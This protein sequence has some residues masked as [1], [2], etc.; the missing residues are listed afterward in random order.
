M[1]GVTATGKLIILQI[2]RKFEVKVE[3]KQFLQAMFVSLAIIATPSPASAQ[4]VTRNVALTVATNWINA[5]TYKYGDWAGSQNA[6]VLKV[7]EFLKNGETIGYFCSVTP[8]GFIVV[9]LKKELAPIKAYSDR[10]NLDPTSDRGIIALLRDRMKKLQDKIIQ[11][12]ADQELARSHSQTYVGEKLS[13]IIEIDYSEAWRKLEKNVETFRAGLP[14]FQDSENPAK[15]VLESA[16]VRSDYQEQDILLS[17]AWHQHSPYNSLCPTGDTGCS[18]C[19]PSEPHTCPPSTTTLVGCVAT[20]GAQIMRYWNWPPY[21]NGSASYSWDNDDSCGHAV[22]GKTLSADFSDNYDWS[23]M[24]NSVTNTSP[25]AQQNAVAELCY[26]V[27]VAVQMDYGVCASGTETYMMEGVYENH[28]RYSTSAQRVN[29]CDSE[30]ANA[31]FE[32]MKYEFDHNRP[33]QY[34]VDRHS[35]VGDGWQIWDVW[36]YYHMNYGWGRTGSDPYIGDNTWYSL[37]ALHLGDPDNEYMIRF[38]MPAPFI[39]ALS[40]SFSRDASFP[41]RYFTRD[42]SGENVSFAGGQ[43]LQFLPGIVVSGT[44]NSTTP[45]V[46]QS[47]ISNPSHLFTQGDITKGVRINSVDN[48]AIK[49][50]NGGSI[51]FIGS[52][53]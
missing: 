53:D 19:C 18:D 35:I 46:F 31:W 20:A 52:P 33:V 24:R 47:S 22:E 49:L 50:Q 39:N 2:I 10:N 1:T 38:I 8:K 4:M 3:M 37:D 45:V 12:S 34:R 14:T 6:A 23:N 27:G 51:K 28:Y 16:T 5:I 41:Y 29:R 40:G 42:V 30:D 43:R 17:S 25:A 32:M 9:S 44:G 26:E 21:G 11:V 15:R 48:S 36:R 13:D 7:Q